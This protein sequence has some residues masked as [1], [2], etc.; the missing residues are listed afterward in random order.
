[1]SNAVYMKELLRPLGVYQLEESFLG[2]ELDCLG[3]AMDVLQE[4]LER[5]QKEMNLVTA[6]GQGLERAADLFGLRPVTQEPLQL[7]RALAA[8]GRIG[9]DSFTLSAVNSTIGGCGVN[10]AVVET[11]EPG[12]VTVRFPDAAG[13]P[14]RFDEL[15][16]VI[17]DI[18]PAHL[19]I[20]YLFWYVTWAELEGWKLTWQT[21]QEQGMT[22]EKFETLMKD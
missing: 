14:E 13:I 7:A 17:E 16:P 19:K 18:L 1:V 8:L 4:E 12:T 15:R 21:A 3:R 22:W 20:Q 6:R 10:A 2:A 5:I 9:W 11:G